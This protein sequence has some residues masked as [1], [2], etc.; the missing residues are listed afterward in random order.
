MLNLYRHASWD[1][2]MKQL[3]KDVSILRKANFL[4]PSENSEHFHTDLHFTKLWADVFW[5]R[6]HRF[7]SGRTDPELDHIVDFLPKS[8][9]E[10]GSAYGRI[11]SKIADLL[12]RNDIKTKLT[13]VEICKEFQPYFDEFTRN[14]PSLNDIEIIYENFFT[15]SSLKLNSYDMIILPMNTFPSF[16]IAMFDRLLDRVK[17]YLTP[18]GVFIFSNYKIEKS[19]I[20]QLIIKEQVNRY[21]GEILLEDG[22]NKILSEYYTIE[23]LTT[24]FG[25]FSRGYT[26]IT[27]A[28]TKFSIIERR[29]FRSQTNFVID[30]FITKRIKKKGYKLLINDDSSHSRVYVLQPK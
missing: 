21:S 7:H 16:A 6:R 18:D 9:L 28:D 23:A 29:I 19:D 17:E 24:K 10:I 14:Q 30:D 13:G 11:L 20:Q 27:R 12:S 2:C 26:S 22:S 15:S 25:F 5:R 3:D 1:I 4:F 8:I